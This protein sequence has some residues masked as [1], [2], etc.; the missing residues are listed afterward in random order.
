MTRLINTTTVTVSNPQQFTYDGDPNFTIGI[1]GGTAT[2]DIYQ[3]SEE[4]NLQ[5]VGSIEESGVFK[6]AG[7]CSIVDVIVSAIGVDVTV[8]VDMTLKNS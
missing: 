8:K 1:V 6:D 5:L 7:S 3:G 4:D 2:V